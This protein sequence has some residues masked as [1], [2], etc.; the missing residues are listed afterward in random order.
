MRVILFEKTSIAKRVKYLEKTKMIER[1][2]YKI[3]DL[4]KGMNS[5]NHHDVFEWYEPVELR[6]P[7]HRSELK[8]ERKPEEQER[9]NKKM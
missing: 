7:S 8:Q 3:E 4:V 9:V 5:N 6:N 1:T 2:K